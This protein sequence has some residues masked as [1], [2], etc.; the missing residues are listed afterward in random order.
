[1]QPAEKKE[2]ERERKDFSLL[3]A[4]MFGQNV[5]SSNDFFTVNNP[6]QDF[7]NI[8]NDLFAVY[9]HFERKILNVCLNGKGMSEQKE[10]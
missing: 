6:Y 7:G 5:K 3:E 8:L 10:K 1:M 9:Q 2:K 4:I